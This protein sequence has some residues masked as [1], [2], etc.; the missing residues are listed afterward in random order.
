VLVPL[1]KGVGPR[2]S[3]ACRFVECRPRSA[4]ADWRSAGLPITSTFQCGAA[5]V[6]SDSGGARLVVGNSARSR[7]GTRRGGAPATSV[8]RCRW[9]QG[10]HR[11]RAVA[12]YPETILLRFRTD[13][14]GRY[15]ASTRSPHLLHAF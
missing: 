14:S 7:H 11:L 9:C 15:R 4:R 5:P 8:N 1:P 10:R 13:A 3:H 12:T 2:A 6:S